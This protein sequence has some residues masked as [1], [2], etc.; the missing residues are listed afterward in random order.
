MLLFLMNI[1]FYWLYQH[2]HCEIN[3]NWCPA[4]NET[5]VF[6]HVHKLDYVY[7][8]EVHTVTSLSLL[9]I[10]DKDFGGLTD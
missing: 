9:E 6:L 2:W 1:G 4:N 7:L 8:A 10:T 3:E 5:T